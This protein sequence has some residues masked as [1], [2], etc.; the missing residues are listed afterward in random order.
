MGPQQHM[1]KLLAILGGDLVR[2]VATG[3]WRTTTFEDA[4]DK[5]GILGDQLRVIAGWHLYQEDPSLRIVVLGGESNSASEAPTIAIVMKH[6]LVELGVPEQA[7]ATERRSFN[8]YQQLCNF[9]EIVEEERSASVL[10][11]SNRYHLERIQAFLQHAPALLMLRQL[12]TLGRLTLQEGEAILI[13]RDS[14][15]WKA[16]ID[17]AYQSAAMSER[18]AHE[19]R[20]VRQIREGTYSFE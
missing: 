5:F 7:I 2:D 3:K 14:E 9:Q 18:I 15:T 19:E 20:G 4:G 1:K 12:H 10:I 16:Q 13:A 6:E 17:A 8:T 11:V